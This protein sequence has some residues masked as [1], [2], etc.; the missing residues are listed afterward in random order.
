MTRD[1]DIEHN[2]VRSVFEFLS[3]VGAVGG[4]RR[5]A[6]ANCYEEVVICSCLWELVFGA[7]EAGAMNGVEAAL[8]S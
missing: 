3:C 5:Q 8:S 7:S 4:L 6:A 1:R 2:Y